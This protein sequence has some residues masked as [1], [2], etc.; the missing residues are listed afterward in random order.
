M[1]LKGL[2]CLEE[3]TK[4]NMDIKG[5]SASISERIIAVEKSVCHLREHLRGY[6]TMDRM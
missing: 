6:I 4:K 1:I 5:D 2:D 3:T